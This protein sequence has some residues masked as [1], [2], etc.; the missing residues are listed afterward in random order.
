MTT[1]APGVTDQC[2]EEVHDMNAGPTATEGGMGIAWQA[3]IETEDTE[4]AFPIVAVAHNDDLEGGGYNVRC[5]VHG[6][7]LDGDPLDSKD[8]TYG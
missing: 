4:E 6:D 5:V 3:Q 2:A 1:N 7:P 8:H